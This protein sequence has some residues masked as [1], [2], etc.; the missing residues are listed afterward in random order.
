MASNNGK[1][2]EAEFEDNISGLVFRLRDKADLVGLNQGKNIAAFGN[3]SDYFIITPESAYLAEVKSTTSKTS[4]SLSGFTAA[5]KAAI[6]KCHKRGLGK[7][8]RIYIHSLHLKQWYLINADDY[9][10]VIK[11]GKKSIKWTNLNTL[12]LW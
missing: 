2:S 3:P 7:F 5:Q 10:K 11:T 1:S 9:M 6:Y 4:F 12:T 8:Y